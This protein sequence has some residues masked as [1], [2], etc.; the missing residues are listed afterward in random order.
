MENSTTTVPSTVTPLTDEQKSLVAENQG[1]VNEALTR[2]K[3]LPHF[4]EDAKQAGMMALC[5]AAKSYDSTVAKFST[6]ATT[7]IQRAMWE[8]VSR[9]HSRQ[10][11]S[12]TEVVTDEGS[13][14]DFIAAAEPVSVEARELWSMVDSLPKHLALAVK[15]SMNGMTA[16]ELA[17]H[18]TNELSKP[19]SHTTAFNWKNEGLKMLADKVKK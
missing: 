8:A 17:I 4:R 9:E 7:C 13:G 19:I 12:E 18:L 5:A 14:L 15:G 2:L 6:F 16:R 10:H 3:V 11:S 1:L